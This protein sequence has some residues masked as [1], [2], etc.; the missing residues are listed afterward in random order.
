MCVAREHVTG[1]AHAHLD[2]PGSFSRRG[3]FG[4]F[5][6]TREG[7]GRDFL[8]WC[9][10]TERAEPAVGGA[11]G[12]RGPAAL[13][14]GRVGP[15]LSAR[16]SLSGGRSPSG[17]GAAGGEGLRWVVRRIEA[18]CAPGSSLST[19]SRF[20]GPLRGRPRRK[21]EGRDPA[22]WLGLLM[23]MNRASLRE[24]GQRQAEGLWAV[25]ALDCVGSQGRVC[26]GRL[27]TVRP[28]QARCS[29][30]RVRVTRPSAAEQ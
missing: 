13:Y 19:C 17:S 6:F 7:D 27:P 26:P 24:G 21:T 15:V 30:S 16:C 25:L 12:K 14:G 9:M 22:E 18:L 3:L 1:R 11:G 28:W 23:G 4:F 2:S 5:F 29:E 20:L 8:P 10:R